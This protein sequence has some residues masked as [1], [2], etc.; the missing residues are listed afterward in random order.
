MRKLQ[1]VFAWIYS[2]LMHCGQ[3]FMREK[4]LTSLYTRLE[5]ISEAVK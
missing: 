2:F 3:P 5:L 1:Y 4:K